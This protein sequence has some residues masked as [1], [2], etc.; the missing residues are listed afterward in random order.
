MCESIIIKLFIFISESLSYLLLMLSRDALPTTASASNM[1][2]TGM[3]DPVFVNIA[4]AIV[5]TKDVGISVRLVM[6]KLSE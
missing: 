3:Y 1:T 2:N 5:A 4:P 6:L